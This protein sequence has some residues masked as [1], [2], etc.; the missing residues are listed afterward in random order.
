MRTE[1]SSSC[2]PFSALSTVLIRH[3]NR[4]VCAQRILGTQTNA[5]NHAGRRFNIFYKV[6]FPA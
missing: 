1:F 4:D 2:L 3:F 6:L 5:S